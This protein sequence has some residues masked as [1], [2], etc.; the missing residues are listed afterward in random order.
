MV[1][2]GKKG[3]FF[4][5]FRKSGQAT[6][7]IY[8]EAFL[9]VILVW[10]RFT[11]I[12]RFTHNRRLTTE[13]RFTFR[14]RFSVFPQYLIS[15]DTYINIVFLLPS[16]FRKK[17]PEGR[18]GLFVFSKEPSTIYTTPFLTVIRLNVC[19]STINAN[20]A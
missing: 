17:I 9:E 6:H 18:G 4:G 11:D 19:T 13:N 10:E 2:F 14:F 5:V 16:F 3:A 8:I 20:I 12:S 15:Y 7:R 1:F